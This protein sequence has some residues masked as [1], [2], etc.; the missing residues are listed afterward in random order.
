[1]SLT[2]TIKSLHARATDRTCPERIV[3]HHVPKCG[4][5]SVGRAIRR[6]YLLSQATVTPVESERAFDLARARRDD[7]AGLDVSHLREMM[8]LYHLA[9][10]RRC[11]AAH[12]PFSDVA[13]EAFRDRYRFLTVLRDPVDRF[14]SNVAWSRRAGAFFKIR[15]PLEDFL[16]TERARKLGATYARYFCGTPGGRRDGWSV[17]KAV[18]NLRRMDGVGFLDDLAGFRDT[19]F[20]LT[21][22]RFRIGHENAAAPDPDRAALREG[23]LGRRIAELCAPDLEIWDAVQHLRRAPVAPGVG[24][25]DTRSTETGVAA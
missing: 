22:H 18:E 25:D 1:M 9:A 2:D 17:A 8:L 5:T 15:E 3:F 19:L 13:F 21:G 23:P 10:D 6:A 4:G 12:V 11:V 20:D 24:V 7:L 14:V 16:K